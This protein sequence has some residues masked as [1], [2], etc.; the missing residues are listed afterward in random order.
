[1]RPK[2]NCDVF[3]VYM[4]FPRSRKKRKTWMLVHNLQQESYGKCLCFGYFNEVLYENEK[5]GG[6]VR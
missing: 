4:G 2:N 3:L 5:Q 6:L 1:M